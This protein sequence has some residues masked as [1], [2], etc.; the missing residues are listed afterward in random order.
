M[1]E[2][3]PLVAFSVEPF[4]VIDVMFDTVVVDALSISM[5]EHVLPAVR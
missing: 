2:E 5:T 1:I 3:D 4:I